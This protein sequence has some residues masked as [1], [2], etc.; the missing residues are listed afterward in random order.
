MKR[1]D[2]IKD[3]VGS[4][5]SLASVARRYVMFNDH[6]HTTILGVRKPEHIE[7]IIQDLEFGPLPEDLTASLKKEHDV[8]FGLKKPETSGI[9]VLAS[10]YVTETNLC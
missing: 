6:V 1:V 7:D 5:Y 10:I 2:K 3:I 4:S 9:L 8:D